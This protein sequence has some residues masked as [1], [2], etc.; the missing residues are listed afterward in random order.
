MTKPVHEFSPVA[1]S[2]LREQK[3]MKLGLEK[4]SAMNTDGCLRHH[5]DDAVAKELNPEG[6]EEDVFGPVAVAGW[7]MLSGCQYSD[8]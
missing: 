5:H 3:T 8:I 4:E 7:R 2:L 6:V 1:S